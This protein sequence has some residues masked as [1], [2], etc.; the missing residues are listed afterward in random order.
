MQGA[1][2]GF[3]GRGI[4]RVAARVQHAPAGGAIQQAGVQMRQAEMRR[5]PLRQGA[6]AGRRRAV[7]GDDEAHAG[8]TAGPPSPAA[9]FSRSAKPGKLVSMKLA[10]STCTGAAAARPSTRALIARR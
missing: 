7:D 10:S 5:Q 4:G 1:G 3:G 2:G 9:V 8:T 6:L